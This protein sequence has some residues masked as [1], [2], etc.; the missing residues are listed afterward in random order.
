MYDLGLDSSELAQITYIP[1]QRIKGFLH[2]GFKL[3]EPEIKEIKKKLYIS[4]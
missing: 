4:Y 3:K 2:S 1:Q